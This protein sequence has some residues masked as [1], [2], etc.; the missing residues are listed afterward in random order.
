M[1]N[2]RTARGNM[3]DME[4]MMAQ[5]GDVIATG[6]MRV[7]A[8]GDRIDSDGNVIE[9]RANVAKGSYTTTTQKLAKVVSTK[10][11]VTAT[12]QKKAAEKATKRS[13][14]RDAPIDDIIPD[15]MAKDDW[16][17]DKDGNFVKKG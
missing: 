4:S 6:N 5:N 15:E 2:R 17:E 14:K 9:T 11:P 8:R 1:T 16:V 3:L 13:P 7:N 12:E 10:E